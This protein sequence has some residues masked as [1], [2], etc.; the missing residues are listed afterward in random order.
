MED[1]LNPAAKSQP[2]ESRIRTKKFAIRIV[3]LF[4]SL[5]KRD[6]ARILGRQLL[7]PGTSVAANYRAVCRAR[8]RAESISK[9]G[10]VLEEADKTEFCSQLLGKAGIVE[11]SKLRSLLAET[12]ELVRIC[13]AS[14]HTAKTR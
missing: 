1:E 3:R 12:N 8:S 14:R 11:S 2:E 7:R 4:K 5:H 6:E 13:F 10:V 9:I